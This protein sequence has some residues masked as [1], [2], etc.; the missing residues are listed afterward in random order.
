ME[1]KK[2]SNRSQTVKEENWIKSYWRPAMGWL[3]M[4]I[5]FVDFVL[6]PALVMFLPAFLKPF[7]V[8]VAYQPWA[9]LTLSNGGLIHMSFGLILG[10][11]AW[12]RGKE[13]MTKSE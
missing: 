7:G 2:P 8:D 1:P 13:K 10:V 6:F 3:Y 12:S 11:S 5:C 9:S 4:I